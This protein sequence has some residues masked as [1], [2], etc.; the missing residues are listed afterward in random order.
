[1]I[2]TKT[3]LL[4]IAFLLLFPFI[5]KAQEK[6]AVSIKCRIRITCAYSS[7]TTIVV[8]VLFVLFY[9][10]PTDANANLLLLFLL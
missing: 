7:C 3:I 4:N 8:W 2:R 10:R 6:D 5:P 1:M 9:Y